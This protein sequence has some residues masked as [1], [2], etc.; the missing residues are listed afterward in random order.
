MTRRGV[1]GAS[2]QS[3]S[4]DSARRAA[5]DCRV[6]TGASRRSGPPAQFRHQPR[7]PVAPQHAQGELP[8]VGRGAPVDGCE[9]DPVGCRAPQG[10]GHRSAN[11]A[12]GQPQPALPAQQP[13]GDDHLPVTPWRA[14][15]AALR[16]TCCCAAWDST[17]CRA[18]TRSAPSPSAHSPHS[19]EPLQQPDFKAVVAAETIRGYPSLCAVTIR[20]AAMPARSRR[21]PAHRC[22][23]RPSRTQES[24]RRRRSSLP[25]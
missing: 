17:T 19:H 24:K 18:S 1:D 25:G 13:R 7:Q 14:T 10:G 3:R 20:R 4:W 8:P 21:G 12:A 5:R 22:S 15:R 16:P 2:V 23:I 11:R 9:G 6:P